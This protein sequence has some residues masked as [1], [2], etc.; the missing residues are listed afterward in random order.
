MSGPVGSD[1]P[2]HPSPETVEI[3]RA[4]LPILVRIVA[5]TLPLL[6]ALIVVTWY[7]AEQR[8]PVPL[9]TLP[10]LLLVVTILAVGHALSRI[11]A[12]ARSVRIGPGGL[13][14][15]NGKYEIS[16]P[17]DHWSPLGHSW[18]TGGVSFRCLPDERRYYVVTP[19]QAR[20]ILR[21]PLCPPWALDET[22]RRLAGTTRD[23]VA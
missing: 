10:A 20:A 22:M 8:G 1:D 6:L 11:P 4:A 16:A 7:L 18:I 9:W 21:H 5:A 12:Y 13:S 14:I 3:A 2:T 15:G 23:P 17:W 19:E